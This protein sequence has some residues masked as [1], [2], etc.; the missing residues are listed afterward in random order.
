MTTNDFELKMRKITIKNKPVSVIA[1]SLLMVIL[2]LARG[3]GGVILLLKGKNVLPEIMIED[4]T[5][6][7]LAIG[8]LIIGIT[9]LVS[10]IGVYFLK[11]IYWI[12]GIITSALF[13]IDGV[14]NG[15]FIYGEPGAMGTTVNLVFGSLILLFLYLARNTFTARKV[16][17]E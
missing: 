6:R 8:L 14:I 4:S 15:Y 17:F 3:S 11:R 10:A 9:E 7:I 13:V 2:A 5:I 16:K 12:I 1:A